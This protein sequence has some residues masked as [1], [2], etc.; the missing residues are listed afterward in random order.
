MNKSTKQEFL[1]IGLL[2]VTI[3]LFFMALYFDGVQKFIEGWN[4]IFQFLLLNLMILILINVVF[5]MI[6]LRKSF[7]LRQHLPQMIGLIL[8]TIGVDIVLPEYHVTVHGAFL[9]GPT[10]SMSAADY[11]MGYIWNSLGLQ[12][13]L[14]WFFTYAISFLIFMGAGAL[15]VKNIVKH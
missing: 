10:F 4:P 8:V 2:M 7:N 3:T 13:F 15:L 12:G 1:Y 5:K 9:H 11:V 6:V 14:L